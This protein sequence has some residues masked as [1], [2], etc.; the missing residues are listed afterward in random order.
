M[1]EEGQL[2]TGFMIFV[3][4]KDTCHQIELELGRNVSIGT[5]KEDTLRLPGTGLEEAHFSFESKED[6]VI[7][8]AKSQVFSKGTEITSS[9]VFVGDVFTCNGVSVYICPKQTDYERGVSLSKDR[10]L[11]IG[12]S[13]ECTV[14]FS[15]KM[16]SSRHARI[17]FESGR[18]KLTDL[19]SKNHTFVNGKR[20]TVHYL[21]DGDVVFIGYYGIVFQKEELFFLNTGKDLRLN[22]EE[23]DMIRRYPFF[24]RSP[25]LGSVSKAGI[26][27]IQEPPGMGERP[28]V[29][30]LAVFLPPLVMAGVSVI[31]MFLSEGSLM[32]LLF[33][34]PMSAVTCFTTVVSYFAQVRKYDQE[35]KKKAESYEEYI[36]QVISR[37]QGDYDNQLSCANNGNPETGYCYDIVSNRMRRLW[38]RS[39][40]DGDFLEVRLG[41]G[42]R[43]LNTEIIFPKAPIGEDAN[44]QLERLKNAIEARKNLKDIAITLP[45]KKARIIGVV[46]NRQVAVKIV[47]NSIVQMVTNHSYVD[48]RLAVIAG[49]EDYKKWAW[50]RWLPHT[51]DN[52]RRTRFISSD[53]KQASDLLE[54]L[55]GVLKKRI[56]AVSCDRYGDQHFLPHMVVVITDFALTENRE[57]LQLLSAADMTLGVSAF[58]LFN[59]LS[60][61]PKECDWFIEG[62]N[63]GG[64]VYSRED[65]TH[66]IGF[67]LDGFGDYEKFARSMAPI[68]D[69]S[70]AQNVRLPSS[71]TFFD[72]YGIKEASELDILRRWAAAKPYGSMAV[73]VG[74]KEDGK[75]F[76]FDIHEK[77]HGP[78]GLVAGTTGSGK[79]EL[80][81]TY[82]LSMC[83]NFSPFDV[84]FVL[85]DFKGTGLAGALK[86]LPHIAGVITDID[87]N[88]Q[89]NLFSLEAEIKRRKKLF[90]RVSDDERKIQDIYEYQKEYYN[91]NLSEPLSHLIVVVDEFTELKSKFPDFMA[92]VDHASRVGRT[93]G[94]HLILATQKP[95]GSVSDE[96]RANSNFKWCLRVKEGES[97]EVMGR[98]EAERIPQEYPGRAYIQAGN[99]EVFELVQTYYSGAKIHVKESDSPVEVS[100]VDSMGRRETVKEKGALDTIVQGKELLALVKY[101][102]SAALGIRA[103]KIWE[104][105]LPKCLTLPDLGSPQQKSLL[106]AIIGLIDD[107]HHQRQ[108]PCEID[109][110]AEGHLLI[111]GAPGTGK[112]ML[113]QTLI[114][115]LAQRYTPDEVHIYIL[116]FGSWSMKNLL[117]LPHIGDVA[118]GNE[119]EKVRNCVK[120]LT[121]T[122]DSRRELFAHTGAG[123]LK[124]YR[125]ATGL[126]LPWIVVLADNF[127]P[128]R[129]MYSELEG[130]LVRL[131]REGSSFGII[132]VVTAAS[133]SGSIGYS[134]SQNFK[135]A[136][137]LRMA[138]QADY[139]DIVGNTEG[140]EP[141]K[142]PGRGLIRGRPPM[143][144]Q[145]ALAVRAEN[146]VEYV[147]NLKAYCRQIAAG[148]EGQLP[149]EIPV[150]PQVV[151]P[152][153]MKGIAPDDIAIGLSEREITPVVLPWGNRLTLISGTEES[154]KTNMLK[155]IFRQLAGTYEVM[156]VDAGSDTQAEKKIEEAVK[157]A[158][159]GE[160]LILFIDDMAK[161]LAQARYDI[162]QALE[163][164]ILDM[165]NNAFS[166]YAAGD[167]AEIS[168]LGSGI[169]SKMIHSGCS[170]VLGGSLDE[171]SSQFEAGNLSYHQREQQVPS[172]GGYLIRKKRALMFKALF[173]GGDEN[174]I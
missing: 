54:Y 144:F 79:S 45:L 19:D 1:N 33:M 52:N 158:S 91:G 68:R 62:S 49:E 53:R 3:F 122:L 60:K 146:D 121:D 23:K 86:N 13:K 64:S 56:E 155:V 70:A 67:T 134:L 105:P 156:M 9:P 150:M 5:A 11:V 96:I 170:I 148:W 17:A 140:L 149:R 126:A 42:V 109:F 173:Q 129:D 51:W 174:G 36:S 106:S 142:N 47:H 162:E 34:L 132:L 15:N 103:R 46:G 73:P 104:D 125:Q 107:P 80:L 29:N 21:A 39:A 87:E 88:I 30:W 31:S 37:I 50:V 93:L 57:F 143:E 112:T 71:V 61:L 20:I 135:Q 167:A 78:H 94:I 153:H 98:N 114:L 95:G 136:L 110:E 133:L 35:K 28:R 127:A 2:L 69:R 58:L 151:L 99:N 25:R 138:D 83:A 38:E 141:S 116:D 85:I 159:S 92:A 160:P 169:I 111:Y 163:D 139:R 24:R 4:V 147:S 81:Q 7:L 152:E 40:G 157:K 171:H 18:Y 108:Y 120:M 113:L 131:S 164:L 100:F 8:T 82:I 66:R 59:S 145:T 32:T 26:V 65:S 166:L 172:H 124:A 41:K 137:A 119:E 12:R 63:S 16:V 6:H 97:R 43:P 90:A 44:P 154:G 22:L 48:V 89:R 75:V 14:C 76:L 27:E 74:T 168:H 165:K 72:G 10:E 117:A 77:C 84:S 101:I 130:Q 118:N 102:C 123:N 161:W 128:I 55:E 115:S